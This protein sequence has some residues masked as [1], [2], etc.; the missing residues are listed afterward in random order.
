[1]HKSLMKRLKKLEEGEQTRQNSMITVIYRNGRRR[2][3][4]P[5]DV[6]GVICD[7]D[8]KVSRVENPGCNDNG[9]LI[10]LINAVIEI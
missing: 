4:H 7:P 9:C 10:E 3:L 2:L 6:I 5:A 8:G 1:M